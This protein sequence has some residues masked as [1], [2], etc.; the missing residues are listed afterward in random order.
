MIAAI[1]VIKYIFFYYDVHFLSVSERQSEQF[2]FSVQ[3]VHN[4]LR[5]LRIL[6]HYR[7]VTKNS[8]FLFFVLKHMARLIS[9]C[10]YT[11]RHIDF[12]CVTVVFQQGKCP[13]FQSGYL[14]VQVPDLLGILKH[15][16]LRSVKEKSK[17]DLWRLSDLYF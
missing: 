11:R 15:K 14:N 5:R 1:K 16:L 6:T 4:A 13:L 10:F 3:M 17:H 12:T 8:T 2:M 7:N 9:F